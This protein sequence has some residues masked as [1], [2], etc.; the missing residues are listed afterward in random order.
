MLRVI[1]VTTAYRTIAVVRYSG[2]ADPSHSFSDSE[3]RAIQLKMDQATVMLDMPKR[4][5][6]SKASHVVKDRLIFTGDS[7]NEILRR[8]R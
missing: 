3:L 2:Y 6:G 8:C 7:E 1:C 4:R 5:S